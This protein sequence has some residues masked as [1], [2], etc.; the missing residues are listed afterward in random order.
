VYAMYYFALITSVMTARDDPS[1][2]N[3]PC[4]RVGCHSWYQSITGV[5][6]RVRP[7]FR[8]SMVRKFL[9][10]HIRIILVLTGGKLTEIYFLHLL[11]VIY[12]FVT[13]YL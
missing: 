2:T 8:K 11:Y 1:E 7:Y 5:I 10:A 13:A 12:Y 3:H 9:D 4:L 6:H